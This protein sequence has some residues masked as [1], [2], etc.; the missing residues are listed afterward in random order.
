VPGF[1][2]SP[3]TVTCYWFDKHLAISFDGDISNKDLKEKP[4]PKFVHRAFFDTGGET[5]IFSSVSGLNLKKSNIKNDIES[6][7]NLEFISGNFNRRGFLFSE[8][9]FSDLIN[10][11]WRIEEFQSTGIVFG[12]QEFPVPERKAYN[13]QNIFIFQKDSNFG[14]STRHI[15]WLEVIPYKIGFDKK[16]VLTDVFSWDSVLKDAAVKSGKNEYIVPVG[17][18]QIKFEIINRFIELWGHP[19]TSEISITRFFQNNMHK[20]IIT[21][22]FGARDIYSEI[23]CIDV[24]GKKIRPDFFVERSNKIC[25]IVE[26][27]LPRIMSPLLVGRT[28]KRKFASWFDTY[29]SQAKKYRRHFLNPA[30]REE[31]YLRCGIKVEYPT[32]TLVVGRQADIDTEEVRELMSEY[33]GIKLISYDELVG[34]AVAQLYL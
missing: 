26:F 10:L 12:F 11:G 7:V 33:E 34:G 6:L 8:S 29:L 4:N 32:V 18:K 27:K 5:Y 21:M 16:G 25:D 15:K 13:F 30:N 20:F 24:S 14:V 1:L 23:N 17:Y 9:T 28:N 22:H 3:K 31:L 2:L 19:L